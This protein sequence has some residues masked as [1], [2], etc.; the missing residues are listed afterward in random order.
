MSD[1][2]DAAPSKDWGSEFPPPKAKPRPKGFKP[3]PP[4]A[5]QKE[6]PRAACPRCKSPSVA[7][8]GVKGGIFTNAEQLATVRCLNC[9]HSWK[10]R[11]EP[12]FGEAIAGMIAAGVAVLVFILW[13]L[14]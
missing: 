4:M 9:G 12:T 14:R 7:L 3:A 8:E 1:W 13:T 6:P 10:P 2:Q 11:P 5:P